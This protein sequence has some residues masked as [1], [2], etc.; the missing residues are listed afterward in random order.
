MKC[1]KI[2]LLENNIGK[3]IYDL[4][5]HRYLLYTKDFSKSIKTITYKTY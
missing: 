2:E 4:G 5:V 1:N 3:Y